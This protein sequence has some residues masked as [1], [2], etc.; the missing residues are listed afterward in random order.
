MS[1]HSNLR[2]ERAKKVGSGLRRSRSGPTSLQGARMHHARYRL[3][4]R[5]PSTRLRR[6]LTLPF[7]RQAVEPYAAPAV[8]R[9][10]ERGDPAAL[11]EAVQRGIERSLF[12][13]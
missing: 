5:L 7:R 11:L 12:H 1:S 13:E 10:P 4:Q 3:R 2:I 9:A 8:G 6:E